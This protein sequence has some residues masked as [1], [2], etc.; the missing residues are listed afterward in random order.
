VGEINNP[1]HEENKTADIVAS[2]DAGQ[3]EIWAS[4]P[5]N[6]KRTGGKKRQPVEGESFS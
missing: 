5:K 3:R 4:M 6:Q 1:F 2:D